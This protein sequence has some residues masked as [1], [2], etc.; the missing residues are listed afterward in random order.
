MYLVVVVC[1]MGR[2]GCCSFDNTFIFKIVSIGK[3]L[4][5]QK[6]FLK[7]C[8]CYIPLLKAT[9]DW[10]E[11]SKLSSISKEWRHLKQTC[12]F[13]PKGV[14]GCGWYRS[15]L[16]DIFISLILEKRLESILKIFDSLEIHSRRLYFLLDNCIMLHTKTTMSLKLKQLQ[17]VKLSAEPPLCLKGDSRTDQGNCNTPARGMTE[18]LCK[19]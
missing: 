13:F 14:E 12:K 6:G 10:I 7:F 2:R 9:L 18:H 11:L 5:H 3:R 17:H 15:G 16:S 4:F 8:Y 1:L 19:T